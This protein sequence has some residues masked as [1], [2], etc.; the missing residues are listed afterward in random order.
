[1]NVFI[2]LKLNIITFYP[3]NGTNSEGKKRNDHTRQLHSYRG[4]P[5]T[6]LIVQAVDATPP[7]SGGE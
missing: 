1:M 6:K 4:W 3:K 7:A 2:K 5:W